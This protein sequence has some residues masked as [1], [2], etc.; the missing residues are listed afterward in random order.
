[1]TM[2]KRLISIS[3]AII[4]VFSLVGLA[5]AQNYEKNIESYIKSDLPKVVMKIDLRNIKNTFPDLEPSVNAALEMNP[6]ERGADYYQEMKEYG[7]DLLSMTDKLYITMEDLP[8]DDNFDA[9]PDYNANT[10]MM[11][12]MMGDYPVSP[13]SSFL[14]EKGFNESGNNSF[15]QFTKQSENVSITIFDQKVIMI[16]MINSTDYMVNIVKNNNNHI[17]GFMSPYVK[18]AMRKYNLMYIIFDFRELEPIDTR[19]FKKESSSVISKF[20]NLSDEI[21]LISMTN[22]FYSTANNDGMIYELQ[23]E[24]DSSEDT[25]VLKDGITQAFGMVKVIAPAM[26]GTISDDED[27]SYSFINHMA[28]NEFYDAY[29]MLNANKTANMEFRELIKFWNGGVEDTYGEFKEIVKTEKIVEEDKNENQDENTEPPVNVIVTC[30]SETDEYFHIVVTLDSDDKISD[31]YI[32]PY[33]GEFIKDELDF[34]EPPLLTKEEHKTISNFLYSLK[35]SNEG[36]TLIVSMTFT[37]NLMN[38]FA[39]LFAK[40]SFD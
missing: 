22:G 31:F 35:A 21:K 15:K 14:T 40:Y 29:D 17:S 16:T 19:D 10:K 37:Q 33:D 18:E 32:E 27:V 13:F 2:N 11:V 30:L 24:T 5:S 25:K 12:T 6:D 39:S 28:N 20:K 7:I 36:T 3:I 9:N 8:I 26:I 38:V 4:M 23:L 1:M 34:S